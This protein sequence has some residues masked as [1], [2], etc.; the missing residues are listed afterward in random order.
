M[1]KD[2]AARVF[3]PCFTTKEV[4][5]GT[6]LGLSQVYALRSNPVATSISIPRKVMALPSRSIFFG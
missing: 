6:G 3:E 1:S 4:G 2:T 5:K